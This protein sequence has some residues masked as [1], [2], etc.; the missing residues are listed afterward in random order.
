ML[1]RNL[2]IISALALVVSIG[3]GFT[4]VNAASLSSNTAKS[5]YCSSKNFKT[6]NSKNFLKAKLDPLVTAGTITQDQET[7][8]LNLLTPSKT[9]KKSNAQNFLKT[10]LD[11]LVTA[12]TITQDQETAVLNLFT[13]SS[14]NTGNKNTKN[15]LNSKLD[16]LVTAGTITQDQETAIKNLFT[17]NKDTQAKKEKST[18]SLKTTLDSLV[19]SGTIT[20]DQETAILNSSSQEKAERKAEMDK[21][22][23]M[24]QTERKAYLQS[25]KTARKTNFLDSLVTS[26]TITKDQETAIKNLLTSNKNANIQAKKEKLTTFLKTKLDTLV[27]SGSIT[28]DQETA[29]INALTA[30]TSK[31]TKN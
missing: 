26:G 1:K 4:T 16:S 28:Q 9:D 8:T 13:P 14:T 19:T 25:K 3:T 7:A 29:M 21:V 15:S 27:T 24:T 11:S 17:S 2:K 31:S 20:Q 6:K 30:S 5:T 10:K 18:N 22:K 12:G 23:N